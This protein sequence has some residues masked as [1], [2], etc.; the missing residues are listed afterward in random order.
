M[1]VYN[2]V[3]PNM[4]LSA[5]DMG[6]PDYMNAL[7]QGMAGARE[8]TETMYK[9]KNMAEALLQAQLKNKHDQVINQYLPRSEEARIGNTE[10]D[11]AGKNI[12][13][14]YLPRSELARILGIENSNVTKRINNQFL[15]RSL[16]ANIQSTMA[17]TKLTNENTNQRQILN[18]FLPDS[19]ESRLLSEQ[20]KTYNQKILNMYLPQSE[21]A[22]IGAA[23]SNTSLDPY[24]QADMQAQTGLAQEQTAKAAQERNWK[25]RLIDS[26]NQRSTGAQGVNGMPPSGSN[27]VASNPSA[28]PLDQIKQYQETNQNSPYGISVPQPTQEDFANKQLFGIDTYSKKR[29]QI[30]DQHKEERN[31][32]T[33]KSLG[34]NSEI[35]ASNKQKQLLDRYNKLMDSS[36]LSGPFGSKVKYPT[37]QRQEIDAIS[38]DMVLN[39]IEELKGAMGS[40]KF[41]DLD[42]KTATSRKPDN[43][44]GAEAR[45]EYTDRFKAFNKR[46]NERAA[47]NQ[48]ASNPNTGVSSGMADR[49]WSAYQQHHPIIADAK[50]L[51]M[52]KY[53]PNNWA[54][55]LTPEAI[56]SVRETGDYNPSDKGLV[57]NL[58]AHE[59]KIIGTYS[60]EELQNQLARKR[61]ESSK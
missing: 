12:L 22:R 39:G 1:M 26:Y 40:G 18:Q 31:A 16:E 52:N 9:P 33:K 35:E 51:Q 28:S 11:K 55:Y 10:A 42:L 25:Q 49:L 24:R 47:F 4:K 6:V 14:K 32:Y 43:T 8:A 37:A 45:K 50:T 21:R 41:T 60:L 59:K 2:P 34:I 48:I 36:L 5:G 17:G 7:R 20:E 27:P 56:K 53:K 61:K 46:I 15:P 3:M 30:F 19:E 29:D 23:E 58:T 54:S 57:N 13:N 38:R 44:W